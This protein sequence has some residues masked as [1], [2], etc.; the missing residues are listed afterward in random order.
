MTAGDRRIAC[1]NSSIT[2]KVLC[3]FLLVST[4]VHCAHASLCLEAALRGACLYARRHCKVTGRGRGVRRGTRTERGARGASGAVH[5]DGLAR[6]RGPAGLAWEAVQ[7]AW[8]LAG[9]AEGPWT[10]SE[11]SPAR[12]RRHALSLRINARVATPGPDPWRCTQRTQRTPRT[13]GGGAV[14][15]WQQR[16]VIWRGGILNLKDV[17]F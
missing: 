9:G 4:C 2:V 3:F 14:S 17:S 5:D 16:A 12:P 6:L 10:C 15:E 11:S 8:R 13:G 1:S 7:R